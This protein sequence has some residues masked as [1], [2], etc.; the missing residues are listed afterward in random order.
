[1]WA[2]QSTTREAAAETPSLDGAATAAASGIAA[3]YQLLLTLNTQAGVAAAE[4]LR[5]A[6]AGHGAA[7]PAAPELSPA[8]GGSGVPPAPNGQEGVQEGPFRAAQPAPGR[9]ECHRNASR[10]PRRAP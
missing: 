7:P 4:A 1:M 2:V 3:V 6:L 8:G 9:A 10:S 5:V